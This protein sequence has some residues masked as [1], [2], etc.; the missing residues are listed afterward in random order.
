MQVVDFLAESLAVGLMSVDTV[1]EILSTERLWAFEDY[2]F[3]AL[4]PSLMMRVM[5]LASRRT[6]VSTVV[7]MLHDQ[8]LYTGTPWVGRPPTANG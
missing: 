3:H 8:V 4:L 2:T 1:I 6:S 5:D 7:K